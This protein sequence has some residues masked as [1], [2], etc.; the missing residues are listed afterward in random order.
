VA[1]STPRRAGTRPARGRRSLPQGTSMYTPGSDGTR[2]GGVERASAPALV[3]LH[4]MPRWV[5]P[6]LITVA[7]VVGL[8]VPGAIG[9]AALVL[10]AALLSLLAYVSWPALPASGRL[11]RGTAIAVM[12]A[13]AA[14]QTVR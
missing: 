6:A 11:L 7:F 5:F 8:A 2:R 4:Q 1:V 14:V 13:L 9:A 3:Y 10:V 12:L